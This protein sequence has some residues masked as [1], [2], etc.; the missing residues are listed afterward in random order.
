MEARK[1]TYLVSPIFATI[2]PLLLMNKYN[3]KEIKYSIIYS[4]LDSF[5][6]YLTVSTLGE[7][8]IFNLIW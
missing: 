2:A 6:L 8:R 1:H 7:L 5:K 3:R 4:F